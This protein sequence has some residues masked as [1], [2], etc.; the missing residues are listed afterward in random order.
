VADRNKD[1]LPDLTL[2]YPVAPAREVTAGGQPLAFRYETSDGEGY[3]VADIF[4]L[5][6]PMK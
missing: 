1:G 5:G 6:A 2:T 4:A 3:L